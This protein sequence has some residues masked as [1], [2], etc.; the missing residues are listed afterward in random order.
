[1]LAGQHERREAGPLGG[2]D[3]G[4]EVVADHEDVAP[5]ERG[6]RRATAS[7]AASVFRGLGEELGRR[8]C[9]TILA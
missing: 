3:V 2:P 4:L 1:V 5:P 9:P 8:A 6:P 7:S